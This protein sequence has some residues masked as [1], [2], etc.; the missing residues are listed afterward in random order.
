MPC[1][2]VRGPLDLLRLSTFLVRH[3]ALIAQLYSGIWLPYVE[4][5]AGESHDPPLMLCFEAMSLCMDARSDP[6]PA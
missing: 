3:V 6:V 5:E 1:F 2:N 4:C